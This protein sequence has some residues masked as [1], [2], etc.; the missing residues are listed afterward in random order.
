MSP[1]RYLRL[2]RMQRVRR[3]LSFADPTS[4]TVTAIATAHGF[5]EL[6]RFAGVYRS[7]YGELPSQTLAAAP[8]KFSES[9]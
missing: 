3:A 2:R 4:A 7:L 8:A 5:W 1:Q 9:A 6:G